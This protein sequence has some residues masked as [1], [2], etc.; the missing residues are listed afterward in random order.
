MGLVSSNI[1]GTLGESFLN[2]RKDTS[3]FIIN[4]MTIDA[5]LPKS[6]VNEEQLL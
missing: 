5:Y 2:H 6:R 3:N 1:S 4:Q